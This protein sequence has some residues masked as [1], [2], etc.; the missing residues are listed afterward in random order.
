MTIRTGGRSTATRSRPSAGSVLG[1]LTAVGLLVALCAG[2]G[3]V[4]VEYE[5]LAIMLAIGVL[6][7]G[8]VS[9]DIHILPVLAFPAT[10]VMVRTGPVSASD[11]VLIMAILPAVLL[12]RRGETTPMRGLMWAGIAYH[13]LL[14]PTLLLN[15]YLENFLEWFHT[16][17]LVLGGLAV[18]WVVGRNGYARG[19]LTLYVVGAVGIGVAA[20]FT[21]LLML[22]QSG[23][24][25]PVYLPFLHKN[26]VGNTLA[27]AF[28]LLWFRPDW[29]R[30]NRHWAVAGLV[31]CA[32]GIAASGAR[33]SIISVF[34]VIGILA[35]RSRANGG[36]KG[37]WLLLALIPAVLLTWNSVAEQVEEDNPFNSAA[38]RLEWFGDALDVWRESPL[39]GV[40]LRWWY[41]GDYPAF[42]PPN[43]F[44]E[45]LSSAG[46]VG[47]IAFL[48][49]CV[50]G[51]W[52]VLTLP[53]QYGQIAAAVMIARFVQGQL[54]LFWVAG[55]A[56]IP[57]M[58]AGLAVG[59]MALERSQGVPEAQPKPTPRPQVI[60]V[61]K[62]PRISRRPQ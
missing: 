31:I 20:L 56:S 15:T 44:L 50:T 57:W 9:T 43:G 11:L 14:V 2:L 37:R 3:V 34:V 45:M 4:T 8:V 32:G 36:G 13:A 33:Q 24:F 30:W 25:G 58:M 59:V 29:L 46:V 23:S 61:Q 28:L 47:V 60:R 18:G 35:L 51:L 52:V 53:H 42:Q 1:G 55:Q 22:V 26:F 12:Y 10:L 7:I 62:R 54:D 16:L 40:G 39:F 49:L 17:A 48:I 6:A 21:G 38:Q 27:F 41:T 5:T 19:A